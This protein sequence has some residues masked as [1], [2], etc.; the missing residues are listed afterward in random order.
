MELLAPK[1]VDD[2]RWLFGRQLVGELYELNVGLVEDQSTV[3]DAVASVIQR[4]DLAIDL[5]LQRNLLGQSDAGVLLQNV[6]DRFDQPVVQ[7]R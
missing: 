5:I 3:D 6:V 1:Q 7:Q 4:C 2:F